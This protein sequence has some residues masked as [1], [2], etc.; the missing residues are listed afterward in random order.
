MGLAEV[1]LSTL[2]LWFIIQRE[3]AFFTL[4]RFLL[5]FNINSS[6]HLLSLFLLL[7]KK[8]TKKGAFLQIAPHAKRKPNADTQGYIQQYGV[9]VG[10]HLEGPIHQQEG[11]S[12][13][14]RISE[15]TFLQQRPCHGFG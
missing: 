14:L 10:G 2:L 11:E 3:W 8:V 12:A 5:G 7:Q 15:S 9:G 13:E 4:V 1:V 6:T